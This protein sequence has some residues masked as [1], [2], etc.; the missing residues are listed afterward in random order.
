MKIDESIK[1]KLIEIGKYPSKYNLFEFVENL[2]N[3]KHVTN[4]KDAELIT[5]QEMQQLCPE[6]LITN[7]SMLEYMLIRPRENKL[8]DD[9]RQWLSLD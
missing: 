9:T 6:I 8:W 5:R 4:D 2:K 3:G 1:K 7:Y